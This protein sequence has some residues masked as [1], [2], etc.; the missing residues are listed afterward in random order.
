MKS[1][2]KSLFKRK[3]KR[4]ND[5]ENQCQPGTQYGVS[6]SHELVSHR[7][8][9][10]FLQRE[11]SQ[12]MSQNS[13]V[14][15]ANAVPSTP[16]ATSTVR[17]PNEN[18]SRHRNSRSSMIVHEDRQEPYDPRPIREIIQVQQRLNNPAIALSPLDV[19]HPDDSTGS[20]QTENDDNGDEV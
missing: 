5:S 6:I 2:F 16:T 15:A 12:H 20:T 9:D 4:H 11:S 10:H 3:S 8:Q 1:V 13:Q 7:D 19:T 18:F 14:P 17:Q